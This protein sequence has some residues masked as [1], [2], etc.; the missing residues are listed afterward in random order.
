VTFEVKQRLYKL[1]GE[2]LLYKLHGEAKEN[3]LKN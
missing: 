2:H 1:H 3:I